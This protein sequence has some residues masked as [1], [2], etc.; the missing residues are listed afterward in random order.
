MEQWRAE[1][2]RQPLAMSEAAACE[3][4]G[5]SPGPDGV[6]TEE[7]MRKAYRNLARRYHPDKNPDPA[8]R[9]KFLVIQKAY[10]RLQAG[11]AGG[12]GPQPWRILLM[13]RAQVILYRRYGDVL[14]PYKYAGY[15]QLLEVLRQQQPVTAIRKSAEGGGTTS[16]GAAAAAEG[17]AAATGEGGGTREGAA[18]AGGSGDGFFSKERMDLVLTAIELCWLTCSTSP[19]NAE[20]LLRAGGV[21]VLGQLLGRCVGVMP[22]DAAPNSEQAVITTHVLRTLAGLAAVEGGRH[23]LG[24]LGQIV[25]DVI[26]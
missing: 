26:R 23:E 25:S 4:L 13:L 3:A 11:A 20:E 8:A 18:A 5:L 21:G 12:Q 17:P 6:V 22:L 14:A 24:G 2:A 15:P 10:H 16:A 9:T 7:E 1:L 19:R